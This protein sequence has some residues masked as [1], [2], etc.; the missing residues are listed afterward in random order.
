[1][2]REDFTTEEVPVQFRTNPLNIL[3]A[4]MGFI[5]VLV[6]MSFGGGL[7]SQMN[8]EDFVAAVLAGN[9]FL[10][11]CAFV[12]GYVGS[13]SGLSFGSLA[14]RIFVRGTWRIA[15]LYIPFTLIGW[16]AI[17]SAI[18]GNLV[19]D[20]FAFSEVTRRAIMGG[21]A[22]FFSI[23]AYLGVR[24]IGRISYLLIPI[25]LL[26]SLFALFNLPKD[27]VLSFG[28]SETK[29][30]LAQ[31]ATIVMTTWIF[32]ALL[33]VPDLARFIRNPL[34]GGIVG[35][36]GVFIGNTVALFIGAFAAAYTKQ[37]DPAL[38]L[39]SLGFTP[40]AMM[41]SFCSIWSTNDNNMYSSSLSVA[42]SLSLPR[43]HVVVGLAIVGAIVA[44]FNPATIGF[45]FSFLSFMGA[46]A[47][48]LAGIVIGGYIYRSVRAD[49]PE[50]VV[51]P[52]LAWIGASFVAYKLDGIFAIPLGITLGFIFWAV[53]SEFEGRIVVSR[54][55]PS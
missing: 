32:S 20:T 23:S 35:A 3:L 33:V 41:L 29:T 31:G 24:F 13:R 38:I 5:L 44:L 25:V 10:A 27:A 39:I 6:S 1:M 34:T 43:Q 52:W 51:A 46:S 53:L 11:V 55:A 40:L 28:F 54:S 17:E 37:S 15:I 22:I 4:W 2:Q 14:A 9:A 48:P 26:G 49:G 19:S 30:S 47:P 7:A 21:A 18:F 42:R 8:R 45:M 36:V 16:Y 12:T 50:G